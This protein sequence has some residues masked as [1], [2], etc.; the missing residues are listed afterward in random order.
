MKQTDPQFKLR[1]PEGLRDRVTAAA[2]TN[3]RSATAEIIARLEESFTAKPDAS[4]LE[5]RIAAMELKSM[6]T[7]LS[8]SAAVFQLLQQ[9]PKQDDGVD[10]QAR[11]LSQEMLDRI[12]AYGDIQAR[13]DEL[14]KKLPSS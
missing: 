12:A 13:F 5:G 4:V 1:I 8:L 11:T 2:K 9:L 6:A 7:E 10:G 3:K 14:L